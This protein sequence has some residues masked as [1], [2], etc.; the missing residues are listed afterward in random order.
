VISRNEYFRTAARVFLTPV[1]FAVKYLWAVIFTA[2][3]IVVSLFLEYARRKS[4][5]GKFLKIT[6][7]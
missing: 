7:A 1:I 4:V 5:Y 3:L 6:K 2:A